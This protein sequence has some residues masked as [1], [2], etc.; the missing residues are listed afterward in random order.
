MALDVSEIIQIIHVLFSPNIYQNSE[1][2]G[3]SISIFC[4]KN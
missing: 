2:D 3:D 1:L 4:V